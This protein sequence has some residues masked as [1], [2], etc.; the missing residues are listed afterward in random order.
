VN[1]LIAHVAVSAFRF[2]S[3]RSV[4][5]LWTTRTGGDNWKVLADPIDLDWIETHPTLPDVALG[6]AWSAQNTRETFLTTDLGDSWVNVGGPRANTTFATYFACESDACPVSL[7][8]CWPAV[9]RS[10]VTS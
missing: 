6:F 7:R 9:G 4:P 1:D 8:V 3:A 5:T 10:R 2:C